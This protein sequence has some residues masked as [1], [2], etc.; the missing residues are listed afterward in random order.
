MVLINDLVYIRALSHN[1]GHV[2]T[3]RVLRIT[4]LL[5]VGALAGCDD[6]PA[7]QVTPEPVEVNEQ[8]VVVTATLIEEKPS[9]PVKT[10]KRAPIDVATQTGNTDTL[11]PTVIKGLPERVELGKMYPYEIRFTNVSDHDIENYY[12]QPYHNWRTEII[13]TTDSACDMLRSGESC[14]VSGFALVRDQGLATLGYNVFYKIEESAN[15]ELNA[16][17]SNTDYLVEFVQELPEHTVVGNRYMVEYRVK[18][19]V[20]APLK[21]NDNLY[22]TDAAQWETLKDTCT[23]S[24]L[25]KGAECRLL[26][27]VRP[28]SKGR[29]NVTYMPYQIDNVGYET[30]SY[31][32]EA[33]KAKTLIVNAPATDFVLLDSAELW[34]SNDEILRNNYAFSLLEELQDTNVVMNYIDAVGENYKSLQYIDDVYIEMP[35]KKLIT[36]HLYSQLTDVEDAP[37]VS[38]ANGSASAPL[39]QDNKPRHKR[40]YVFIGKADWE[41]LPEGELTIPLTFSVHSERRKQFYK[42]LPTEIQIIKRTD[43]SRQSSISDDSGIF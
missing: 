35:N 20:D 2:M 39:G 17:A 26:G 3:T 6:E 16:N 30:S 25:E 22:K 12:L 29:F 43:T 34:Q 18:N 1:K 10:I 38:I 36:L 14:T 19:I 41:Y 4:P 42:M 31:A 40:V 5:L 15:I 7:Q 33:N 28:T 11:L 32:T 24:V 8:P 21:I 13:D 37:K 9:E 27:T 23:N